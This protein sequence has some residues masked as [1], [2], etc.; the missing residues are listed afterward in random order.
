MAIEPNVNIIR[1]YKFLVKQFNV[2]NLKKLKC[3]LAT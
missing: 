1:A 2:L 3:F